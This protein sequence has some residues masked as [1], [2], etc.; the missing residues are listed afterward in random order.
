ML[1]LREEEMVM[2]IGGEEETGLI[3]PEFNIGDRVYSKSEPDFGI[4]TITDMTYQQGWFYT[5]Q[6]EGGLL[7]TAEN[8][9]LP[10]F[11]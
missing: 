6:M 9:L 4:G 5:V 3:R 8:D 2:V 1:A 7:Y 11:L 10:A